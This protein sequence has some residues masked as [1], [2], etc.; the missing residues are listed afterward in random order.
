MF[1]HINA[2]N[3][4][5]VYD[6]IVRQTKFAVADGALR[7][8]ELVPSVREVARELAINPNTV[9]R[10]YRQL[11]DDGVLEPVRGTGLAVTASARRHCQIERMRLIRVRLR[12]VLDE[13][14][15]SGLAPE[16]IDQLVR[17]ESLAAQRHRQKG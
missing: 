17:A 10:A 7:P 15:Q 11:Q 1:L 3:G 5:A 6:Q 14:V 2:H 8:G 13:A 9:A 4:L 16:E 12:A